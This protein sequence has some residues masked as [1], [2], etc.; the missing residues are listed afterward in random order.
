M[1]DLINE[2]QES[3]ELKIDARVVIDCCVI[4][5]AQMKI[6]QRVWTKKGGLELKVL[7]CSTVL[8]YFEDM[9]E[10]KLVL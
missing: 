5:D 8:L 1:E 2:E 7:D 10:L 4:L 3:L 9:G 6:V